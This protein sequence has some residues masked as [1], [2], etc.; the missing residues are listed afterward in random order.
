[1]VHFRGPRRYGPARAAVIAIS[2]G[3]QGEIRN[4][5]KIGGWSID[6]RGANG[7]VIAPD[8]VHVKGVYAWEISPDGTPLAE[9]S[10]WLLELV[11]KRTATVAS[12]PTAL[13]WSRGVRCL[14]DRAG[15]STWIAIRR[16]S[17]EPA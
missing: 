9:A 12:M 2:R 17:R 11:T 5:T 3:R 14:R 1:M 13:G 6:V 16:R 8:S 4:S 10:A 15:A 7:Y